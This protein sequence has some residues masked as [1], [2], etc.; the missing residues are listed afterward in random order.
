MRT[1]PLTLVYVL[2]TAGALVGDSPEQAVLAAQHRWIDSYNH[3]DESALSAIEADEFRVTFGDGRVQKKRDQVALL[4]KPL[5]RGAEY[6]IAVEASEVHVYGKAAVV[7]GVV[8]E[9]GKL[10]N[11][12]GV[13]QPFIQRSRY[14]DTWILRNGW[15]RVVASHLSELK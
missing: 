11:E 12:Q 1:L 13:G 6:E 8:A 4:R 14:T 5:P 7:T 2:L 9:R 15:W 10:P 3:R